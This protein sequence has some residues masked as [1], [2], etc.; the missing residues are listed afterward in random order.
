MDTTGLKVIRGAASMPVWRLR[1]ALDELTPG[2]DTR[3]V[4][5]DITG[6]PP[7]LADDDR[8][9]F[10]G[11]PIPVIA[12]LNGQVAGGA[13]D[14]A[15]CADIR[16]AGADLR[17]TLRGFGSRRM[18]ALLGVE[19][20]VRAMAANVVD[21][22]M[23]LELGLV[24]AVAL[25]GAALAEAERLADVIASRGPIATR[26][27]KEALWHGVDM[28]FQDALRMETDLTVLL[29]TTKD[30]AEGVAAF[31]EKRAPHFTGN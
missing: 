31:L 26:M 23:A 20:Q 11:Y 18:V 7:A 8:H 28:G 24:S 12:A 14:L 10:E 22:P 2:Y 19:R 9:W 6:A 27:A 3:V 16:A 5:L 13:A 4:V 15:L 29:Q 1:D 30:R 17:L 21:A 25:P